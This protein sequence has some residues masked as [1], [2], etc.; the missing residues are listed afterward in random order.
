M[1]ND[2]GW[3][4]MSDGSLMWYWVFFKE[5]TNRYIVLSDDEVTGENRWMLNEDSYEVLSDCRHSKEDAERYAKQWYQYKKLKL[6]TNPITLREASHFINQFHRHHVAP[7]GHKFSIALSD[8]D[9]TVGAIIAGRPVSRHMDD[10]RTLE[11]TR[12]C[13]KE[14]Y[15]NGV[16]Q[17]YAAACKVAKAMGYKRVITYTLSEESG[18]SMKAANF[19]ILRKSKGG[20]WS[21]KKRLRVDKHPTGEKVLWLKE[22]I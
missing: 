10:G 22:I 19:R 4:V 21:A 16:S 7:Q 5:K 2:K 20:S 18:T 6:E 15:K 12:C 1:T 13:V 11:I 9:I 17:L 14:V 3:R 8:G